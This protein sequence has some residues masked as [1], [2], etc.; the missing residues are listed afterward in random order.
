MQGLERLLGQEGQLRLRQARVLVV[1]VGGVGTWVLESLARS[2]VGHLGLVDLDEICESN[3]NRQLHALYS[4][5]G[6]SKV[7]VMS[8]RLKDINP[9]LSVDC[10]EEFY[11]SETAAGILDHRYDV[12]VDAVDSLRAK[13]HLAHECRQ[14]KLPLIMIGGAAGKRDPA[15]IRLSDLADTIQDN[16]LFRVRKK[17]RTE[18]GFPQPKKKM[19]ILCVSSFEP[20]VYPDGQGGVCDKPQAGTTGKLDC[21]T[22]MGSASFITGIFGLM[23]T[24]AV[25]EILLKKESVA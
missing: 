24:S 14:R 23:A 3:I 9:E 6:K 12:V 20:S 21:E 7:R 13:V 25:V 15:K 16:L 11:T 5:V 17:L 4:T 19:K 18:F 8:E 22:G 10:L 2:G 1:G